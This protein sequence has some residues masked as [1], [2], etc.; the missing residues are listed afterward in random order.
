M[1]KQW[2]KQDKND[3]RGQFFGLRRVAAVNAIAFV[4]ALVSFGPAARG[5]EV[6]P[7][8]A[9]M[10]LVDGALAFDVQA[11]LESFVAGIDLSGVH[12]TGEAA[13]TSAYDALRA[14][15]PEDLEARFRAFWPQMAAQITIRSDQ[16]DLEPE[17]TG[18]E[19]PSIENTEL[20]RPSVLR[21]RAALPAGATTVQVGWAAPLGVLVL[22][23][24]GVEEP[25]SGYLEGGT[26]SP[27]IEL[28]TGSRAAS[29]Q[30][31][32]DFVPIGFRQMVPLGLDHVL[33]VLGL[34]LLARQ[35][36]PL[37]WQVAAFTLAHSATL[38]LGSLGYLAVPSAIVEPLIAVSIVYVAAENIFAG[39]SSRWRLPLVF[40]F[41][42]V[43]GLG[44]AS[45]LEEFGMPERN[46]LPALLGFNAGVELGQLAVILTAFL[47]VGLWFRD[48]SWYR[49]VIAIP[50][51]AGGGLIGA[52][53]FFERVLL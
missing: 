51:S 10:T 37:L 40:G 22:R 28:P 45:V 4:L 6:V 23:Q 53:W 14:M 13:D 39:G 7:S 20:A 26:I 44:L 19:I 29:W 50:A 34:L 36:R 9:D 8:V 1:V 33:F 49:P 16:G 18:V 15:P 24:Q 12:D 38:V 31:F 47:L 35:I 32:A 3:R 2:G 5:H 11:N 43:H 46:V 30:A 27:P 42:L 48:K 41:G 52:W 25:Y 21:F 17:L